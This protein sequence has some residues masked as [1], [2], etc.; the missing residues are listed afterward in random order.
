[1]EN[2]RW[3]IYQR[4]RLRHARKRFANCFFDLIL[5]SR[6]VR[7]ALALCTL[8][9]ISRPF[10]VA[11]AEARAIV[12]AELKFS[13][14]TCQVLLTAKPISAFH[15]ALEIAEEIFNCIRIL[16][17]FAN[18]EAITRGPVFNCFVRGKFLPYFSVQL[19]FVGM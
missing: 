16:T 10:P 17:V 2:D 4:L 9:S 14:I 7:Q 15:A 11:D 19:A 1:M 13:N 8:E 3:R 12:V 18:I 6:P 5:M